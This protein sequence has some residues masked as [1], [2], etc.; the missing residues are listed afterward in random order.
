MGS[1]TAAGAAG[2]HKEGGTGRRATTEQLIGSLGGKVEAYYFAFGDDFVLIADL[3][4]NVQAAAGSLAASSAGGVTVR[5]TV[6]LTP[7]EMDAATK[8]ST[9]YRAPGA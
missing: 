4:G 2:F 3:P 9:S 8:L 1:Y 5:T 6:P 7:E